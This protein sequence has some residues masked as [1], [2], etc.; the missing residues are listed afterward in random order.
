MSKAKKEKKLQLEKERA[1]REEDE[2]RRD[3]YRDDRGS[4]DRE[5]ERDRDRKERHGRRDRS[6]GKRKQVIRRASSSRVPVVKKD[7][8]SCVAMLEADLARATADLEIARREIE[9]LSAERP[10]P[11]LKC[12]VL[13]KNYEECQVHF[14]ILVAKN[15]R[16]TEAAE[17]TRIVERRR[18][19]NLNKEVL[20]FNEDLHN[21]R[22]LF[23]YNEELVRQPQTLL[24]K[25]LWEEIVLSKAI[26]EAFVA[27]WRRE[28]RQSA[29][30]T[31]RGS[32][33][34]AEAP[35]GERVSTATSALRLLPPF[36][37]FCASPTRIV[38][39]LK[40]LLYRTSGMRGR[41]VVYRS[42][43]ERRHSIAEAW[44]RIEQRMNAMGY[45]FELPQLK[46]KWKQLKDQFVRENKM[47]EDHNS[48][49]QFY[50]EMSFLNQNENLCNYERRSCSSA[51]Y[52]SNG[53][54]SLQMNKTSD[55]GEPLFE[56]RA[57][58]IEEEGTS[59]ST[60]VKS[61]VLDPEVDVTNLFG[62]ERGAMV[63]SSGI[64]LS[65]TVVDELLRM[66][67]S[68]KD[69]L[70]NDSCDEKQKARAWKEVHEF[71]R[72]ITKVT[73]SVEELKELFRRKQV[74][75]N[76]IVSQHGKTDIFS[77]HGFAR[78][79]Q[80][81]VSKCLPEEKFS[82]RERELGTYILRKT[83][84]PN[85]YAPSSRKR[86]RPG[87]S[88]ERPQENGVCR[89]CGSR[90]ATRQSCPC[91]I[92]NE[93]L[94]TSLQE[95]LKAQKAYFVVAKEVQREQ[96]RVLSSLGSVLERVADKL[97]SFDF[98]CK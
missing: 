92:D 2:K 40:C 4:R 65:E 84:S 11:C 61:E 31:G 6:R 83:L 26:D 41:S 66:V 80:S 30:T 53:D 59:R 88:T 95:M 63:S 71:I 5:R 87:D 55:N 18:N 43:A 47:F 28:R 17:K 19:M 9:E 3:D 35:A 22:R 16:E 89:E 38:L 78:Y 81:I 37:R 62:Q 69:T 20:E 1:A 54:L 96:L 15:R 76:D 75:I 93:C 12:A 97:P 85:E 51:D 60:E 8:I 57:G 64:V 36:R 58:V 42:D 98:T 90:N 91:T 24:E 23:L 45:T 94:K 48:K 25:A 49:W 56:P 27:R 70:L 13:Q 67:L 21:V 14:R 72:A 46:K 33:R 68:R 32:A 10:P 29:K 39:A 7:W 44:Q 74:Y 77:V 34:L 52:L 82:A 73:P 86:P 79:I 50:E